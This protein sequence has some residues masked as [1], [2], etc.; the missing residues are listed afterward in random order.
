MRTEKHTEHLEIILEF[1]PSYMRDDVR[2]KCFNMEISDSEFERLCQLWGAFL[3]DLWIDRC[4]CL[5]CI[6]FSDIWSS[7]IIDKLLKTMPLLASSLPFPPLWV[8]IYQLPLSVDI[9]TV[10]ALRFRATSIQPRNCCNL[11][12]TKLDQSNQRIIK[13]IKELLKFTEL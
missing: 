9:Y 12:L 8:I 7:N 10:Q 1:F 3:F 2:E 13:Q 5:H 4:F 11:F 6:L